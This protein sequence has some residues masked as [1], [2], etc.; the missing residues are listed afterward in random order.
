MASPRGGC[1][2]Y[3][4]KPMCRTLAEADEMVAACERQHVKLALAHQTRYS[5]RIDRVRELIAGGELGEIMELRGRGKEDRRAGGE[6]LM[7]LGSHI[8]DLIRYLV[9]DAEWCFARVLQGGKPV[10]KSEVR[11]G[12]EGLGPLA[13]DAINAMYGMKAPTTA[14]FSPVRQLEG[15]GG[16]F[17]LQIFGSK[18]VIDLTTGGLPPAVLLKDPTWAP[19]RSK[20]QWVE[21]TSAG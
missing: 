13:G 5:P 15:S 14:Y 21:V 10:T 6:D 16:R 1:H 3:M 19:R 17:G 2:M 4:E 8:V 20:K 11:P 18:G 12:N 7:V 9:G